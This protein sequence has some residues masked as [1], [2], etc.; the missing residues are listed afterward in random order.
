M[1]WGFNKNKTK[2]EKASIVQKQ[3]SFSSSNGKDSAKVNAAPDFKGN[4]ISSDSSTYY[5]YPVAR[6]PN[7]ETGDTLLIKC[8]KY[9]PP[10]AETE[11]GLE[12]FT[13]TEGVAGDKSKKIDSKPATVVTDGRA[14][15]EGLIAKNFGMTADARTRQNQDIQYY[16]ELP[17][18]QDINDTQSVTWGEDTINMFELAGLAVAKKFINSPADALG[19]GLDIAQ[20]A[21]GAGIQIPGLNASTQEAFKAA[22]GGKA[23]SA[24]GSNVSPKSIISRATGQVLNSNLEL[25]FQGVNLRSFPFSVT[26]SPRSKTEGVIVREIIRSLKKSMSAKAGEDSYN[27][28]SASGIMIASPDV[29]LLEYRSRGSTHP[30]LNSFKTCALAGLSVN[31]TNSGTY[32]TY[33]DSTPVNI[34]LDMTFKELN[35]IYAEDYD[36]PEAGPGVGY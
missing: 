34:R 26:F 35:P 5:S 2:E 22:I 9:R 17:I 33:K 11:M 31:Y 3:Y 12:D 20:A 14:A 16:I 7:D 21:L 8:V 23:I 4:R 15:S 10:T 1:I 30:F 18:P 25:L 19:G 28:A 32:A 36:R 13:V 29:F 27:G 24:L 6:G